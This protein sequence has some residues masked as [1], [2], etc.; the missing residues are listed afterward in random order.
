MP[1]YPNV[2]L[3]S[4]ADAALGTKDR[5]KVA[6][7]TWLNRR[8]DDAIAVTLHATDV[9]TY[10]RDGDI[11]LCTGGYQ[12]MTT[13]ARLVMFS[14]YQVYSVKGRW[15]VGGD[16]WSVSFVEG[17][18]ITPGVTPNPVDTSAEDAA[19]V[20]MQ[21]AIKAYVALYTDDEQARLILGA[22]NGAHRGDCLYCQ[23]EAGQVQ[24]ADHKYYGGAASTPISNMAGNDHLLSHMDEGYTMASLMMLVVTAKNRGPAA[25]HM[26]S[27]VRD[28][29]SWFLR[30]R[31]ITGT[32]AVR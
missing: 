27:I 13:K 25:V 18:T 8:G 11:S 15:M 26:P 32:V 5:R 12:S 24:N 10:H 6:N 29:L 31:L 21:K 9:V 16:G 4:E 22:Q 14:P 19:N 7:N 28:D 3:F 17:I 2:K 20:A 30:K 1:S 23:I